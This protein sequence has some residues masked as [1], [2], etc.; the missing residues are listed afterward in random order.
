[1]SL[2]KLYRALRISK[3]AFHKRYARQVYQQEMKEQLLPI[4]MQIRDD[5]PRMAAREMYYML[6][7]EWIGRDRFIGWLNQEGLQVRQLRNFIRTTNSLGVTRFPN[8][9]EGIE[10]TGVNQ[11]WVS[12][13]TYYQLSSKVFYITLI[14]DLYSRYIVGHQLS[15]TLQTI[16]TTIPAI[17]KAI[18]TRKGQCKGLIFHSDGGGQYYSK[19]F[20]TLTDK[21][22]M[23]NSMGISVYENPHIERLH[24]TI[25]NDYLKPKYPRNYSDLESKLKINVALYNDKRPHR[26]LGRKTPLQ[27]EKELLKTA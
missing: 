18:K 7:P 12:D 20:R 19:E 14:M 1:M 17:K 9:I 23:Q 3:Q 26:S 13:I 27:M 2:N 5:H 16:D 8:L 4:I 24:S 21:H 25:K 22:S 11:V 6:K 15:K 10:L